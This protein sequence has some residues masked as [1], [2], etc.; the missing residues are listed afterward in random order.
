MQRLRLLFGISIFWLGLSVLTDGLTTLVLP[1]LLLDLTAEASR[2]TTLGLLTFAGLLLAMLVQPI[3]GNVSDRL[4]PRWGRRGSLAMSVALVLVSLVAF[5]VAPGL[6]GLCLGFVFVQV[7]ASVSQAA[8]QGFIPDLVPP[9]LRGTASGFKGLMDIGGALVGFA[10][11]GQLLEGGQPAPALL[12]I[13]A[14]ILFT[15]LLTVALVREPT[16]ATAPAPRRVTLAEA[17]RLDFR[18]HRAFVRLVA[19][20]FLFLL[21]AY[22]V[23]RFWLFFIVDR[24]R[25]DPEH[26]SDEAGTL[27]AGLALVTVVASIPAGWA[28]DR[29]G[30]VPLMAAGVALSAAGVLLLIVADSGPVI[31][32][33]GGLMAAGTAAFA[34]ANWA[35]TADLV[36]AEEAARFFGLANFGTAGAAAAAGLAGPLVDW[37]NGAQPGLGYIALF[38]FAALM[39]AASGWTLLGIRVGEVVE[40]RVALATE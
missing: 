15:F 1:T 26:A 22:T 12:A 34:G 23:S 17:F 29:F 21:G 30:R 35:L 20:R 4:R 9:R 11:L 6:A 28:A 24:L 2:A 8:Q 27:L 37:A 33:F 25:L 32:L 19:C 5:G 40:R 38:A 39:F 10:L 13:A 31:F 36:P 7:A 16:A 18:R 14:I 3:A